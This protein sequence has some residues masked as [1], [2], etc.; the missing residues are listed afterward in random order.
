MAYR[1]TIYVGIHMI[2]WWSRGPSLT[3]WEEGKTLSKE[4]WEIV[5]K[6]WTRDTTWFKDNGGILD[7][8]FPS[9][10]LSGYFHTILHD[11]T[12]CALNYS[13]LLILIGAAVQPVSTMIQFFQ[14]LFECLVLL[15][16]GD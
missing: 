1:T 10:M 8:S 4:A 14:D 7:P 11:D 15:T 6:G 9:N 16:S 3:K 12:I 13:F 5:K 2:N